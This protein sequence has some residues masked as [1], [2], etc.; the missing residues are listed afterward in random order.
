MSKNKVPQIYVTQRHVKE[1]Y[2]EDEWLQ[3]CFRTPDEEQDFLIDRDIEN[4]CEQNKEGA[5][6]LTKY[7]ISKL[8]LPP[9]V[10]RKKVLWNKI[11]TAIQRN[12]IILVDNIAYRGHMFKGILEDMVLI[13]ALENMKI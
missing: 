8:P 13:E 12:R 6:R 5:I 1:V 2:L 9:L 4:L 11:K 10:P 7:V 3:I